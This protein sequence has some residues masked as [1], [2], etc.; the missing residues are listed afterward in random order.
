MI[1]QNMIDAQIKEIEEALATEKE[2]AEM[3]NISQNRIHYSAVK[4][5]IKPYRIYCDNKLQIAYN[6]EQALS[7]TTAD[8]AG[9][10]IAWNRS[11]EAYDER[12]SAVVPGEDQ[13]THHL[14]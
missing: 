14:R 7:A 2:L 10:T 3:I 6:K 12:G 1:T 8:E 13:P 4:L 9:S 11:V 5:R